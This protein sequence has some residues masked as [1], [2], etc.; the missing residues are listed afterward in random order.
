MANVVL[1]FLLIPYCGAIGAAVAS[2]VTQFFTNVIIGFI[3]KPIRRNNY[4]MIKGL[5]PKIMVELFR[6]IIHRH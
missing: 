5:N 4:L 1:N 3:F 2:L 6:T